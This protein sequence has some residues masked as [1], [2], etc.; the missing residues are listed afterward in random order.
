M[1]QA[2]YV[3]DLALLQ[4]W[5]SCF[6]ERKLRAEYP[7]FWAMFLLCSYSEGQSEVPLPNHVLSTSGA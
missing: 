3:V 5:L 2:V 4:S 6:Q 1:L 7:G